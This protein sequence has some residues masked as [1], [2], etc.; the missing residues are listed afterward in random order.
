VSRRRESLL[1]FSWPANSDGAKEEIRNNPV[2]SERWR[3]IDADSNDY[4]LEA[5]EPRTGKIVG[6]TILRTGKGS[7]TLTSAEAAGKFLVAADSANR[8]HVISL[9]NGEQKGL[10]FGRRP[11]LS[12]ESALLGAENDRGELSLYDLNTMA[13][14]QQYFF[15]HPISYLAFGADQRRMLVL[16][17]DQ[18]VFFIKLPAAPAAGRTAANH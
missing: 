13:R 1:V 2:F 6:A 3:K 8:L 5:L 4:F 11:A 17:G 15:T 10:L 14:R 9:D 16:T 12:G 7:F 18:T